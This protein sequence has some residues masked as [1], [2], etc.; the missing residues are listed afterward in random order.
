MSSNQDPAIVTVR[1]PKDVA[2]GVFDSGKVRGVENLDES[3]T[4][5]LRFY[6]WQEG[7]WEFPDG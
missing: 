3:I 2:D 5:A 6:L 7:G 4:W 1:I